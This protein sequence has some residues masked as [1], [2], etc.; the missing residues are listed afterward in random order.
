MMVRGL[1]IF[2]I[3]FLIFSCKNEEN[4][5]PSYVPD[6]MDIPQGFPEINFPEGNEFTI[7]RWELGKKLF[8]D[9][10]LSAD[11]SISCASCHQPK[12]AFSDDV[13]FSLGVENRIGTRNSPTLAN[14]AYHPY[15]TREG[16][17][18]TLEMQ[19]LVPIQ[20]HNEFDFN[21]VLIAERL[22]NDSIYVL[23]SKKAYDRTPDHFVITRAL[24]CFERSL[25]SGYSPYDQY[26]NYDK[27][28]ALTDSEI[29]GMNLFFSEKTN[30]SN[31]HSDFNFSNYTFENNGL[32][33]EYEDVGRFRLTGEES[34]IALFKTPSLR[35]IELTAPYM[36]DGS[37]NSL[38]EVIDHYNSG[39]RNHP[40]KNQLIQP[41]HLTEFEKTDLVHFLKSLTDETFINNKLFNN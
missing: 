16:G 36:H 38:E 22:V 34:D 32:Y 19:I 11:S 2:G 14:V 4:I 40:H 15:F 1:Y 26:T 17:V 28:N 37:M 39:G 27:K 6:L 8:F 24:A 20:E 10:V 7:A 30:C 41:L 29:R 18:P 35:N 25:L 31:C 21:I 12:L 23:M 9:P 3:V 5:E 13:P 33:E